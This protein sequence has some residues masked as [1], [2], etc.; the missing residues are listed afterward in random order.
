M[1]GRMS[2][3][4][5]LLTAGVIVLA[6]LA[7][8]AGCGGSSQPTIPPDNSATIRILNSTQG[9]PILFVFFRDCNTI[10]WGSD[11][12]GQNETIPPGGTRNFTVQAGC[13]D[14]KATAL[15]APAPPNSEVD[16]IEPNVTILPGATFEWTVR[17]GE[18]T[19]M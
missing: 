12:L 19:Q 1:S 3:W 18:E 8:I 14:L 9:G 10:S 16:V 15:T 7:V 2:R 6:V 11:Q 13:H 4:A 17:V 5:S